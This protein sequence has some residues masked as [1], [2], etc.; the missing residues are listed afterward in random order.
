MKYLYILLQEY[1]K[2]V[3]LLYSKSILKNLIFTILLKFK[4]NNNTGRVFKDLNKNTRVLTYLAYIQTIE[5]FWKI[6][7]FSFLDK[8]NWLIF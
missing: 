8:F 5:H 1:G 6:T 3:Y 4:N 7:C 2:I